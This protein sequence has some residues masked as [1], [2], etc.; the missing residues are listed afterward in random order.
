MKAKFYLDSEAE[1]SFLI[2]SFPEIKFHLFKAKLDDYSYYSVIS[3]YIDN[4]EGLKDLWERINN[5]VGAEYLTSVNDFSSWNIYLAFISKKKIDNILKYTIENDTF[6]VRKLIFDTPN[7]KITTG[8][9]AN[10]FNN[11]I[12]GHDIIPERNEN[13]LEFSEIKYSRVTQNLLSSNLPKG[14]TNKDR[15]L[16]SAWLDKAILEVSNH[17]V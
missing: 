9:L 13:Q 5:L 11:E 1:I 15:D 17:E 14:R 4:E 2:E 10:I 3:C 8:Q 6:F 16:Q 7:K 12:L